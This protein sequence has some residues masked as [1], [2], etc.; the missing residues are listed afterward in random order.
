MK[1]FLKIVKKSIVCILFVVFFLCL[2]TIAGIDNAEAQVE[3]FI[4]EIRMFGGNY[5]PRD[6]A[7]CNGQLLQIS[8]YTTLF[9]IIGTTYGGDG[10]TTFALPDLRGR[11][12][13][14]P[15][16]G[17]G[18]SRRSLG[19]RGGTESTTLSVNQMPSHTHVAQA[20]SG[21]GDSSTPEGNFWAKSGADYHTAYNAN[22]SPGAIANTGGSQA[23]ENMQPYL[24]I[25]FIIA[26][27]GIF[28]SRP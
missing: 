15:G 10:R 1:L 14:H 16:Q 13:L 2:N 7:F 17:P 5:A 27:E 19:Q 18:L 28:P 24:G 11:V 8:Q 20:N 3:P 22:M 6:W 4:G 21:D 26:L 23:H 12:P 9:A 25:H